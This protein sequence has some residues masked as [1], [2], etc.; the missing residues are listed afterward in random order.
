MLASFPRTM[1][2]P[3]QKGSVVPD[4]DVRLLQERRV[5]RLAADRRN[6]DRTGLDAAR[7]P[8]T[9]SALSKTAA[10]GRPRNRS[11]HW[12]QVGDAPQRLHW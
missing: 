6:R 4:N 2:Q 11:D 7:R 9:Y 1:H 3:R 8:G 5:V 12:Q 10:D